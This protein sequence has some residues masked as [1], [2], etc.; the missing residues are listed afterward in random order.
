[1]KL[2]LKNMWE[3]FC[4]ILEP[5]LT[6]FWRVFKLFL[7]YFSIYLGRVIFGII[8]VTWMLYKKLV[9]VTETYI[10]NILRQNKELRVRVF[11]IRST[12]KKLIT[13]S[14]FFRARRPVTILVLFYL[15]YLMF[16]NGLV[17]YFSLAT[18]S[19]FR[20]PATVYAL[21][22][23]DLHDLAMWYIFIV[24]G[25]V[26]WS[27][28]AILRNCVWNVSNRSFGFFR[29]FLY[30]S[31]FFPFVESLIFYVW[32]DLYITVIKYMVDFF[33]RESNIELATFYIFGVDRSAKAEWLHFFYG[34]KHLASGL[35]FPK[36]YKLHLL[37]IEPISLWDIYFFSKERYLDYYLFSISNHGEFYYDDFSEL[38]SIRRFRHSLSL[39]IVWATFPTVII[40][41]ILVPSL[42]LLYSSEEDLD[43]EFTIKVIGHQWFWS[44][45]YSDFFFYKFGDFASSEYK[46]FKFDSYLILEEDLAFGTKRLLEVNNRIVVP[47][48][49]VLRF[50]ITS[51]D[52]IHSWAVPEMGI[53]VD[54]VPG[55]LNQALTIIIRPGIFYGQCSELCGVAHGFMPIVVHAVSP[56]EF[57]Y[58]TFWFNS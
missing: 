54:A 21:A 58:W 13:H 37:S 50:L 51:G 39:E 32:M 38:L 5:I 20:D 8:A 4:D 45:E 17:G 40:I 7:W 6:V 53:K 12:W 9:I 44:Y 10:K 46:S 42:Y 3:R 55:R 19:T 1:M 27:L 11:L 41:L 15:C 43:P 49:I 47:T 30:L 35:I 31:P 14:I 33:R 57:N 56:K 34:R 23:I 28:Y 24:L 16:Y 18:L 36:I 29:M 52:V 2:M 22:L 26:C 48:N 25:I